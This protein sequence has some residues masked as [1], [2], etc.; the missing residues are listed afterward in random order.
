MYDRENNFEV[1]KMNKNDKKLSALIKN[2]KQAFS[3]TIGN[4]KG[5]V[6]KTASSVI[7]AYLLAK[8][9]FKVLVV[10]L[11]PQANATK[12][13]INT[14]MRQAQEQ[15]LEKDFSFNKTLLDAILEKNIEDTIINIIDNL[16]IV[17]SDDSFE[18]FARYVYLNSGAKDDYSFDH[19]LEPLF[20]DIKPKYD[21]IVLDTPPSN[22]EIRSNAVVMTD[23]VLISLQTQDDSLAGANLYISALVDLKQ[24]YDLPVEVVGVLA[25]L[26][27][28]RNTVDK[29]VLKRAIEL[30]SDEVVFKHVLPNMSRMK[31]FPIQGVG[32]SDRFDKYVLDEYE[33]VADELIGKILFYEEGK[34]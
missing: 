21:F 4:Q 24:K 30:F 2:R 26:N 5:G 28:P 34:D 17:P 10:D 20:A 19:I 14:G 13:L 3:L 31:R 8:K 22:K 25:T 16:D 7:L 15:G 9:G 27:D 23:Y 18:D 12:M 33:V 29:L 6:G 1:I 32:T 11:D